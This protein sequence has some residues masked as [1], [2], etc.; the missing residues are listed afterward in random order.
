MNIYLYLKHF[1]PLGDDLN[2]GTRKAVHGLAIGLAHQGASVTVLC[3]GVQDSLTQT[4][5]GYSIQ[6][7]ANPRSGSYRSVAESASFNIAPGLEPFIRDRQQDS[8]FI[9]NGIFH[10]SLYSF[11]K[12]LRKYAVPYIVAPH[13]PYHP[14]IFKK[15]AHLKLPY[16]HLI[17]KPL[18]NRAIAI[19]VLD[20]R[21]GQWLQRLQVNPP[22]IE[23]PNGFSPTDVMAEAALDWRTEGRCKLIFLGRLD[24]YN[25]GLDLLL[26]AFAQV[27]KTNDVELVL[28]GPDWGDRSVL[29][30]QATQLG[31]ADRV[32]FLQPDY[33]RSPSDI[34]ANHDIFC[35]PSRFEGFS[36]SG[37]EAM[38]AGRVILISEIAGLAPHITASCC[39][40]VVQPDVQAIARGLETLLNQRSAWQ[41]MGL[42]GRAYAL[43]HLDWNQI[44]AQALQDYARLMP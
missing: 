21:H 31:I 2:E 7:F 40:V 6:C 12:L 5:Y 35:V 13:D 8:L 38:L 19:Q 34:I 4:D 27:V 33:D 32:T 18:L 43:K 9:L 20:K 16:W 22:V 15:N 44:G 36:L 30:V 14:A 23:V 37:L 28:Q 17:E 29:K 26:E 11:G 1:P 24:A 41:E 3:E 10:R 39:G 25:K 42:N